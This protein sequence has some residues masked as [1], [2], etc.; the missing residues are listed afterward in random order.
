MLDCGEQDQG[1]CREGSYSSRASRVTIRCRRSR[2]R[3]RAGVRLGGH[4]LGDQPGERLDPGGGLHP[5]DHVGPVDVVGGQILQ[6]ALALVLV[7]DP[8]HSGLARR[9][10]GVAATPGLDRGLL[11]RADHE[12]ALAERFAVEDPGV[13]VQRSG[14]L[15]REVRIPREDPA[16]VLPWL[17]DVLGQPAAHRGRRDRLHDS[18]G[19]RLRGQLRGAPPRQRHPGF[20]RQLTGQ[21]LDA[22]HRHRGKKPAAV[23]TVDD[24]PG[25]VRP[26][27]RTVCAT[28]R[29][30]AP[31]RRAGRR[32]PCS[33]ARRQP[34]H[35]LRPHHLVVRRGVGPS[36]LLQRGPILCRQLDHKRRTASHHS[37]R[38][39][40]QHGGS[41]LPLAETSRSYNCVVPPSTTLA[42][43][44]L[45]RAD[46]V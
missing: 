28:S 22:H 6:R 45:P 33:P 41:A 20:G 46:Y 10:G 23:R 29:P 31:P 1:G 11:I 2:T 26:P 4:D 24:L 43:W 38:Q 44:D 14:R 8:H 3:D 13:E 21:R 5:A 9:Q 39:A 36:A 25:R 7:L 18:A 12:L 15:G 32:S 30:A 42:A 34:A 35:D 40:R 16:A 17:E 19:D 37:L 27:R